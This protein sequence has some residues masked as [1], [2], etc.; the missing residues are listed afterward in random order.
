MCLRST[1]QLLLDGSDN[2]KANISV[3][4]A[5]SDRASMGTAS[6]FGGVAK[7]ASSDDKV[8]CASIE[9]QSITGLRCVVVGGVTVSTEFP[10]IAL[11]VIEAETIGSKRADGGVDSVTIDE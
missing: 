1:G 10:Y 7:A 3:V 4:N 2:A 8:R 5:G 11:H 9:A 6:P